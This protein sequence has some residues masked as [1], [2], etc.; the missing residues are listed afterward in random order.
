MPITRNKGSVDIE[1]EVTDAIKDLLY[2]DTFKDLLGAVVRKELSE[3]R[4]TISELRSEVTGLRDSNKELIKLLTSG[5]PIPTF[6]NKSVVNTAQ[7][8]TSASATV[9]QRPKNAEKVGDSARNFHKN[10]IAQRT[11]IDGNNTPV[12]KS[13]TLLE[14]SNAQPEM[15]SEDSNSSGKKNSA[16]TGRT[17]S[18]AVFGSGTQ[19]VISNVD[20]QVE[21]DDNP[22][23]QTDDYHPV[24]KIEL[25]SVTTQ[26]NLEPNK[27]QKPPPYKDQRTEEQ[28]RKFTTKQNRQFA[29]Q[30]KDINSHLV[31]ALAVCRSF[32][33]CNCMYSQNTVASDHSSWSSFPFLIYKELFILLVHH[34]QRQ[35]MGDVKKVVEFFNKDAL[36]LNL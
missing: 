24:L 30:T 22:L 17:R 36:F 21:R 15:A 23:V 10:N 6:K 12:N 33:Y 18:R 7:I 16:H 34:I 29:S 25:S 26:I 2:S 5:E 19:T 1:G 13:N 11:Q 9:G 20:C 28:M 27:Q 32:A 31:G 35:S 8:S 4:N 14:S 3:L